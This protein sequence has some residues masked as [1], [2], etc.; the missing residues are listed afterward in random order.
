MPFQANMEKQNALNMCR[1]INI[2]TLEFYGGSI[3]AE[4]LI[5]IIS[6]SA[7]SAAPRPARGL[8]DFKLCS[9]Q[10]SVP[11]KPEGALLS[12]GIWWVHRFSVSLVA[13]RLLQWQAHGTTWGTGRA[14]QG[15]WL[16]DVRMELNIYFPAPFLT[17][18]HFVLCCL[19]GVCQTKWYIIR[20]SQLISF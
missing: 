6:V 20:V 19:Q 3:I 15:S 14:K 17:Y 9:T 7:E 2:L 10:S 12:L 13:A 1:Q 18:P 5:G 16:S 8:G 4:P 11:A